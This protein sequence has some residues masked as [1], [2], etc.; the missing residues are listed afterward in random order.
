MATMTTTHKFKIIKQITKRGN[1]VNEDSYFSC[2]SFAF[3]IDGATAVFDK[4]IT[5]FKSDAEWLSVK[6]NECLSKYLLNNE[7]SLKEALR[8]S[9]KIL[10]SEYLYF[11]EQAGLE[12]DFTIT[13]SAALSA[14]RI[15]KEKLEYIGFADCLVLLETKSGEILKINS[16]P[17]HLRLDAIKMSKA[18]EKSKLD[19]ISVREAV[20]SSEVRELSK[21]N[22][23]LRNLINKGGYPVF[24]LSGDGI[25]NAKTAF[26]DLNTIA[27]FVIMSDG[28]AD[29]FKTYNMFKSYKEFY[30]GLKN[31]NIIQL[32]KQQKRLAKNDPDF[33]KFPRFKMIDDATLVHCTINTTT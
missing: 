9:V 5:P 12:Y 25:S 23:A 30:Y 27:G 7:L 17:R 22:R 13:P 24:D 15:N 1:A 19:K 28:V 16:D 11:L 3:V 32:L 18:I 29:M 4:K 26:F 21:A 14:L 6:L 8:E 2:D 10:S 31:I 20:A 33:N